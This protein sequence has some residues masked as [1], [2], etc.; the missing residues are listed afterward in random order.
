MKKLIFIA[1]VLVLISSFALVACQPPEPGIPY[2]ENGKEING[3]FWSRYVDTE[4]GIVC[5]AYYQAGIDCVQ[6]ER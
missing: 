3:S 6:I 1:L 5:Y 2:V 4:Y